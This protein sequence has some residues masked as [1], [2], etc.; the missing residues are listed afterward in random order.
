[1][2]SL[3]NRKFRRKD[4]SILEKSYYDIYQDSFMRH[5]KHLQD[6]KTQYQED[7]ASYSKQKDDEETYQL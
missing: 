4:G 5:Q 3:G 6:V 7:V 1:M 2:K